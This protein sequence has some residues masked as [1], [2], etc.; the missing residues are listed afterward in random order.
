[1]AA[2]LEAESEAA[3]EENPAVLA[4]YY[5]RSDAPKKALYY[6]ERA[7]ARAESLDASAQASELWRRALKAARA[8]GDQESIRRAEA[9]LR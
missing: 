7:A 8:I 4:F 1:V 3:A 6:L 9:A 2:V 5:Y